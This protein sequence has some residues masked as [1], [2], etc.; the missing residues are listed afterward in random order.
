V[1]LG[2]NVTKLLTN[3][4]GINGKPAWMRQPRTR[5]GDLYCIRLCNQ[6]EVRD[7]YAVVAPVVDMITIAIVV[8]MKSFKTLCHVT[9]S[10]RKSRVQIR[11]LT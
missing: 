7:M 5:M 11:Q 1:Q 3:M 4:A 9:P 10:I 2:S 6:V 8:R